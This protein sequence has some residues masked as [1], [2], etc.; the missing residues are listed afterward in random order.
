MFGALLHKFYASKKHFNVKRKKTRKNSGKF[1]GNDDFLS[2]FQASAKNMPGIFGYLSVL[3]KK[4]SV[5]I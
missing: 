1:K 5:S 3:L 4:T 2:N